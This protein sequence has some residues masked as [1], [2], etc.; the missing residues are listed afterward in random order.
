MR[1]TTLKDS[2]KRIN[3]PHLPQRVAPNSV[4]S[5]QTKQKKW[6]YHII[7]WRVNVFMGDQS[8]KRVL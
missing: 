7:I 1:Y 2:I 5:V 8:K 4:I 6:V 3:I